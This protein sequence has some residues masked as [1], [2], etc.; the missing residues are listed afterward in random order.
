MLKI[1]IIQNLISNKNQV[2]RTSQCQRFDIHFSATKCVSVQELS[3]WN[4]WDTLIHLQ[5]LNKGKVTR[6]YVFQ[7]R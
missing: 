1:K 6:E 5:L 4:I 7:S 2:D 3:L